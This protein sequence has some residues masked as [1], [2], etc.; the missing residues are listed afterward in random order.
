M[1]FLIPNLLSCYKIDENKKEN[2][3]A[4]DNSIINDTPKFANNDC[5]KITFGSFNSKGIFTDT[6]DVYNQNYGEFRF[7]STIEFINSN[8]NESF[9][10]TFNMANSVIPKLKSQ[11]LKSNTNYNGYFRL[12]GSNVILYFK[13]KK[14]STKSEF[15]ILFDSEYK[16]ILSIKAISSD[17]YPTYW[18]KI[19]DLEYQKID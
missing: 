19:E 17:I 11:K 9:D 7:E 4:V 12:N 8:E 5:S 13:G 1:V 14:T 2:T 3:I 6:L 18:R 10:G 16:C 15:E